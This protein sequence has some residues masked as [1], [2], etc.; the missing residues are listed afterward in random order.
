MDFR[1]F[2][3]DL[4]SLGFHYKL[5]SPSDTSHIQVAEIPVKRVAA[6]AVRWPNF[7]S[8]WLRRGD[9]GRDWTRK[10]I[11]DEIDWKL[12]F[13]HELSSSVCMPLWS[14]F[15]F[16]RYLAWANIFAATSRFWIVGT[17]SWLHVHN[18]SNNIHTCH[19][20]C[21]KISK[22]DR[23]TVYT[24][25]VFHSLRICHLLQWPI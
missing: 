22:M 4:T 18:N 5:L 25:N 8:G 19:D 14:S 11:I 16:S 2:R 9:R 10:A 21:P 13:D 6:L 1:N 3:S 12:W 23:Q 24:D 7:N 17:T 15:I 20:D